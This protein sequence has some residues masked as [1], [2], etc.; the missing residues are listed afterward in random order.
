MPTMQL[1]CH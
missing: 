1:M